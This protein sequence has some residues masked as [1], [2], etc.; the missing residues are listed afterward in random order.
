MVAAMTADELRKVEASYQRAAASAEELRA[1]RN[2]AVVAALN[3][4]MTHADIARAT[5]LSRGRVG[6]LASAASG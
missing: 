4:G 5:G 1:A 6:Q 2:A 3:A